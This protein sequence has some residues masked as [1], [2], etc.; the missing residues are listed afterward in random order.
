MKIEV[1]R[2]STIVIMVLFMMPFVNI[3]TVTQARNDAKDFI[4]CEISEGK[5]HNIT[6]LTG[7]SVLVRVSENGTI[8]SFSIKPAD[9]SKLGQGFLSLEINNSTYIIPSSI[10]ITK[11]D[12]EIFNINYLIE[13]GYGELPYIPI[14]IEHYTDKESL[15]N[16]LEKE[17]A[18]VTHSFSILPV[19]AAKIHKI[20][21]RSM[22]EPFYNLRDVKKIWLDKKVYVDLSESMPLIGAPELWAF[23]L[24]G[25]SVEIA[26]LDTGIDNTHPCLDDLDDDPTTFDPK[27][28]VEKSF[29]EYSDTGTEDIYGHGTHVACIAA[30]TQQ[31]VFSEIYGWTETVGP[32]VAPGANLWNIKVLD[33]YGWGWES[34]VI[35]G[36]EYA[37][38][39]PDG[40]PR[41]GDE[42]DIISM[43]LGG[44]PTDGTNP[45]SMA[46]DA[47]VDA[48]VTVVV[49]AGNDWDYF[50]INAPGVARKAIT[51]GASDKWDYIAYFSSRGPTIDYR[52]KPDLLAPGFDITSA[53]PWGFDWKSGTSMST[54]H[55]AGT[56]A[57]LKQKGVPGGLSEPEY[58]KNIL[59]STSVDLGY[60]VYTQGGGRLD[61]LS[62]AT[63]D[64]LVEP[65]TSSLGVYTED[66][67]DSSVI[68][69]RNLDT[70]SSRTLV[71]DV[72]VLDTITETFV[73]CSSLNET[74][75]SIPPNSTASVLL[76]INTTLPKSVYS[77]KLTAITNTGNEINAIFGFARL[78]E[79]S[80]NV[81]D[82]NGNPSEGRIIQII[83]ENI[84]S[85]MDYS[86]N[87]AYNSIV[88]PFT[89]ENGQT[90]CYTTD[91]SFIILSPTWNEDMNEG[92]FTISESEITGN[93]EIFLDDRDTHEIKFDPNKPGQILASQIIS[94]NYLETEPYWFS[95]STSFLSYYPRSTLSR[96]S[97]TK[98]NTTFT[99]AYY[100]LE[101]LVVSD[102]GII[103]TQEWHNLLYDEMG[104][105]GPIEFIANN[106]DLV[107][108]M[109]EYRTA[110]T[111]KLSAHFVQ[112][113]RSNLHTGTPLTFGWDM[114]LPQ[115]RVEYLSPYMEYDTWFL[116]MYDIPN[117]ETPYW[118]YDHYGNWSKGEKFDESWNSHPLSTRFN[119][120][121]YI[122]NN[123]VYLSI[124]GNFFQDAY[125][126]DFY[127]HWRWPAG[128]MKIFINNELL[129]EFDLGDSFWVYLYEW[130]VPSTPSEYLIVL[131]GWSDQYLSNKSHTEI[132]FIREEDFDDINPPNI[133]IQIPGLDLNNTHPAGEVIANI[134]IDDP[135]HSSIADGTLE[136]SIDEGVTWNLAEPLIHTL[137]LGEPY[138][139]SLGTIEDSYVSLRANMTDPDGNSISQTTIRGFYI[140]S[141]PSITG[142]PIVLFEGWN[143]IGL[144]CIPEDPS[145]EVILSEIIDNIE[146]VWDFDGETK[147]WSSYSPGAPSD[148]TEMVEGRGYWIKVNKDVILTIY[149]DSE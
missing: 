77:G 17:G 34:W 112:W 101:D 84:T 94:I 100:P 23:G 40:L 71:L 96:I 115:S 67:I 5:L 66:I 24:N 118:E 103:D 14:L 36:I 38:Y 28:I 136:Y 86:M 56:V 57:L 64:I 47:A 54:P 78:N 41:T 108:K 144:P 76:T 90:V 59:I 53:T 102:P 130:P 106:Y 20:K 133:F 127:N 121:G 18:E 116:K 89:D 26:I 21:S 7:D 117:V 75:L 98:L 125:E 79:V 146:C 113:V 27:V 63:T 8:L 55:V 52:L 148:L 80:I 120:Y 124:Y 149:S 46:V 3:Y 62:A 43:S 22:D 111:P 107:E 110:I 65:A 73:D 6:L 119:A 135:Y 122:L 44:W 15:I 61:A 81:I 30:G 49:A 139:F 95:Y 50:W 85:D 137:L 1:R 33:D 105:T 19:L 134:Y 74:I 2:L 92:I 9:P 16:N 4:E 145:I 99:Y 83:K 114:T 51:V 93:T 70:T 123:E 88:E 12:L 132:K 129:N 143:L 138:P 10:D 29:V 35:A 60:D 87:S 68:K 69:F 91:G 126:H 142:I 128:H 140:G 141:E 109:T 25:S 58:F 97:T 147:T 42:S 72:E 31:N 11:F 37:A 39:G 45:D 82:M 131:D 32:G 48:G 13:K 104:I